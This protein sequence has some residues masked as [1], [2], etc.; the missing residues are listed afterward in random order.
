MA[1]D[2][3]I[4]VDNVSK[5]FKL[6]HEKSSSLKS[7]LINFHK[8][9]YEKQEVLKNVN[10]E[11]QKGEFFG[12]VGRNGS[13]KST[14]LK[15]LAGIYSPDKG[16]VHVRGKLTPFIELGVGFNPELTGRENVFLNG[17]LLGFNRREMEGL[18]DQIVEFAELGRFM[19]QK[20][21]NYSSGM[22]VRLAFSIA[23]RAKSDILLIDEVLA[24]GDAAFQKKCF[25][26]FYELKQ[27][28]TTVI[29]V[30]HDRGS[31]ER[32][33]ERGV[34]IEDGNLVAAGSIEEVLHDYSRIVLNELSDTKDMSAKEADQS[35]IDQ[36]VVGAIDDNGKEKNSFTFGDTIRLRFK[37]RA[38]RQ[39]DNPIVGITVW[40]KNTNRAVVATNT[41]L[42]NIPETGIYKKGDQ[43]ELTM[44]LPANLNDG[45]YFL[46]PAIAN[47]S[48][49]VFY[50][51]LP[52]A[53]KIIIDGSKN[54]HS[55]LSLSRNSFNY[56]RG[57]S[58]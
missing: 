44:T 38:I 26:Y 46:E 40:E 5:S 34:L 35:Y 48:A 36:I 12:I 41:L 57:K 1:E 28:G 17:A 21:K 54:P 55:L 16:E 24:V 29:F 6:P 9:G 39:M 20:L 15:L 56:E 58:K 19:D 11:I 23:I 7:A 49:T 13:G 53:A 37:F 47:L 8:R 4:R 3:A 14:L 50:A 33:C 22:Q 43:V 10:F 25:D 18:Y 45:E 32:F 30:S 31:L 42:E 52:K 51:Q 27:S 2:F